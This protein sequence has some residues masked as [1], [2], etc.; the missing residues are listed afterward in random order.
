M[1]P[2]LPVRDEIDEVLR[3]DP[4]IEGFSKSNYVF[5]DITLGI[6]ERVSNLDMSYTASNTGLH[7]RAI[8]NISQSHHC[9]NQ[10]RIDCSDSLGWTD[11]KNQPIGDQAMV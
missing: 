2:V 11:Y 8:V 9:A 6:P 4:E 3:S 5:T 1:P 7:A 10:V